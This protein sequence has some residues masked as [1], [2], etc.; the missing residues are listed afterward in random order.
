MLTSLGCGGVKM[1]LSCLHVCNQFW[2]VVADVGTVSR[3]V[4]P[5]DNSVFIFYFSSIFG[6]QHGD[7]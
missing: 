6:R 1:E 5:T 4:L 3:S 2:D 7:N